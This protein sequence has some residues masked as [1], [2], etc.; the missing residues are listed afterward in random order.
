MSPRPSLLLLDT[1][2][3][4][5]TRDTVKGKFAQLSSGWNCS[6]IKKTC[7]HSYHSSEELEYT[8]GQD[9][10]LV[11]SAKEKGDG[12]NSVSGWSTCAVLWQ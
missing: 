8:S 9:S 6:L 11:L 5:G 12:Q 3:E 2:M 4:L 1:L 7:S 10:A